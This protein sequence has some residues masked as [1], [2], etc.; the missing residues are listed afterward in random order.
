[1][2]E[3]HSS[4]GHHQHPPETDHLFLQEERHG[5]TSRIRK[6]AKKTRAMMCF[7]PSHANREDS[8]QTNVTQGSRTDMKM[9]ACT[10]P[11]RSWDP[12]KVPALNKDKVHGFENQNITMTEESS[13]NS[14]QCPVKKI[15]SWWTSQPSQS[16]SMTT[17][18]S[19]SRPRHR[20]DSV[21]SP[22]DIRYVV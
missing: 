17:C 21:V 14:R 13:T 15:N 12:R 19:P 16:L 7:S 20:R 4:V 18:A 5:R 22:K 6:H 10:R 3:R 2:L 1:V 8:A 11:Y 9:A